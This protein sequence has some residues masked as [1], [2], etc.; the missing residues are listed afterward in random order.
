MVNGLPDKLQMLRLK[1]GF[2]Q[3]QVAE[4]LGISPSIV[5]SYEM[6]ARTPSVEVLLALS[7]LYQCSTDY[8]LGK[9][10]I[11]PSIVVDAEG[12]TDEQIQA[13]RTIIDAIKSNK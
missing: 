12:L 2:S 5:S 4:R 3:R 10:S 7:F 9:Q 13:I 6:G 1:Y 8:L 11:E